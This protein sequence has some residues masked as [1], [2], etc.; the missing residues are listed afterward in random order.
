MK[1]PKRKSKDTKKIPVTFNKAQ[2]E[3]IDKYKGPL[4]TVRSQVIRNI[5]I[6]WLLDRIKEEGK[7]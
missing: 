1:K 7:K 4:G 3:M 5:V 2:L 6:N